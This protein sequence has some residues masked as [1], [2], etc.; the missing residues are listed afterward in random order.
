M[1]ERVRRG[2]WTACRRTHS[3]P[4]LHVLGADDPHNGTL[5]FASKLCPWTDFMMSVLTLT[6][7]L[8]RSC[9][10]G[11]LRRYHTTK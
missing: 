4:V 5:M 6:P 1:G 9:C 8:L 11:W 10:A 2:L 3:V 7:L